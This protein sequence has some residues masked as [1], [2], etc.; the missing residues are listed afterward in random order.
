ME[1]QLVVT[2]EFEL[3]VF[4]ALVE[5]IIFEY[6]DESGTY[7]SDLYAKIENLNLEDLKKIAAN[8]PRKVNYMNKLI[9]RKAYIKEIGSPYDGEYGFITLVQGDDYHLALWGGNGQQLLFSRK[10]LT[11]PRKKK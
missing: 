1:K 11:I 2:T 7:L 10:E 5:Q 4:K 3:K 6:E 8:A 9:G